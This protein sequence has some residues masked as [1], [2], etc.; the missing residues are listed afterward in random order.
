MKKTVITQ[1]SKDG[2]VFRVFVCEQYEGFEEYAK[3]SLSC[4]KGGDNGVEQPVGRKEGR[5]AN[6]STTAR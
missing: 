5:L 4:G 3:H 6:G 1:D 2:T